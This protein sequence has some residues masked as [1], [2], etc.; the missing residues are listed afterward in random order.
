[1]CS[2]PVHVVF[3]V[4]ANNENDSIEDTHAHMDTL[5]FVCE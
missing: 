2:L 3:L 4:T 1:M 5:Y